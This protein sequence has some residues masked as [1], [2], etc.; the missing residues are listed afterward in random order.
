MEAVEHNQTAYFRPQAGEPALYVFSAGEVRRVTLG[1]NLSFG[2]QT[3]KNR[4]DVTAVSPV[5]SRRHGRFLQ[6]NGHCFYE[7]LGS[8]NGTV[9]NGAAIP[10]HTPVELSDG[11][12]LLVHGKEDDAHRHDVLL[13]YTTRESA[14]VSWDSVPLGEEVSSLAVGREEALRLSDDAV[15]RHHA[16]FFHSSRGWA[17]LDLNSL[18]GVSLNQ[19]PVTEPEL[20]APMDVVAIAGYFFIFTPERLFYGSPDARETGAKPGAE[21]DETAEHPPAY[22]GAALSIDIRERNVWHRMKKKTLLKDIRLDIPEG[23]LVLILAG[24]GAG[25]TTFMNA[26]MG[27]ERAE[28][29][30][31]YRNMDIYEEFDKMKY[32]IGYVPQQDLLRLSDTVYCTLENSARMRMPSSATEQEREQAV[33]RTLRLF[34]LERERDSRISKLSGGQKKR[35]SIAVEYIGN[36]ALFFLDEPD[37]GLDGTMSAELFRNLREI[38]DEGKIVLVISHSPD[39]VIDLLDRVIVLAKSAADNCGR[40]AFYGPVSEACAFF[41]TGR[42]LEKIVRRLNRED[43]G[44]EGK[45]DYYINLFQRRENA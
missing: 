5:L 41:E 13:I 16:V 11:D 25:K 35:L 8:L 20:L 4:P 28:G 29:C 18:N 33:A 21:S 37:S 34:A 26:V 32:Q 27:Y 10:A 31:F 1:E 38:A 15:S 6:I 39:R 30:V 43:E 40:L 36:P 12:C 22:G 23:N 19:R 3:K 45:S 24:S 2:R 9:R 14:P 42:S 7:D 44:G 17:I